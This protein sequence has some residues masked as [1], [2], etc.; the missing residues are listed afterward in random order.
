MAKTLGYSNFVK[1]L[2]LAK[3]GFIG[4]ILEK[5]M[6]SHQAEKVSVQLS[7]NNW[8]QQMECCGLLA[9]AHHFS[10]CLLHPR[11]PG[12]AGSPAS[13]AICPQDG[14]PATKGFRVDHIT[15]SAVQR[16][17]LSCL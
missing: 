4:R 2:V 14:P 8:H 9:L 6:V 1:L 10:A 7:L 3:G 13:Q 11:L 15:A 5:N 16:A 17:S 12:Q